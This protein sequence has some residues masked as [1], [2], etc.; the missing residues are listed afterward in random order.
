MLI[1]KG[2][3]AC[4]APERVYRAYPKSTERWISIIWTQLVSFVFSWSHCVLSQLPLK[5]SFISDI[6]PDHHA[7]T[8]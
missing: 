7:L 6:K 1:G 2:A 3:A 4:M 8:P 5:L